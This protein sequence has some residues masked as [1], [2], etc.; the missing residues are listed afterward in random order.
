M[1]I[2][3]TIFEKTPEQKYLVS[4]IESWGFKK[5]GCKESESGVE[6]VY[7]REFSKKFDI[8]KYQT[9]LSV[10]FFKKKKIHSSNTP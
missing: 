5:H 8:E 10:Y 9:F 2:Y 1:K 3:L 4:L 7:V 6:Q